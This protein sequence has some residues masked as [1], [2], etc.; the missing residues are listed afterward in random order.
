MALSDSYATVDQYRDA[1][2]LTAS[3]DDARIEAG[4]EAASR[5]IDRITGNRRFAKDD[6][7]A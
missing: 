5:L 1:V 2:N 6:N 3:H 4:L 7:D